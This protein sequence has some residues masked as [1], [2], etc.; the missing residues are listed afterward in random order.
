MANF[1]EKLNFAD[2]Q[3]NADS[4]IKL[5]TRRDHGYYYDNLCLYCANND[6]DPAK[7]PDD[8]FSAAAEIMEMIGSPD[9]STDHYYFWID[10]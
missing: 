9:L 7:I 8:E 5:H 10:K 3:G 2:S 1:V 4:A 6:I